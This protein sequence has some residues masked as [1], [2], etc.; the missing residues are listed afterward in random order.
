M[1]EPSGDKDA[2]MRNFDRGKYERLYTWLYYNQ[3]EEGYKCKVCET[4]PVLGNHKHAEKW[5]IE[6]QR[7]LSDHPIRTLNIHETSAK[8]KDAVQFLNNFKN[9]HTLESLQEKQVQKRIT[10]AEITHDG[11]LKLLKVTVFIVKKNWAHTQNFESFVRFVGEELEEAVLKEYLKVCEDRKN[12]TYLSSSAVTDFIHVI[13]N[14]IKEKTL[15][16]LR[17]ATDFTLLLDESTDEA[18]R[19]ELALLARLVDGIEVKN[20]FLDLIRLKRRDAKTVFGAVQ[21]FLTRENVDISK[22]RFAG[23]DG[24]STM[25]GSDGGVK[26]FFE[27]ASGHCVYVHCR[28]HRLALCFAH[29]IP[30]Y[31]ILQEFDSLL[32]NLFLMMKH[33]AVKS[34]IFE[35]VQTAYGVL[36]LKLIKGTVTRWLSHG[37]ACERVLDR[38]EPLISALD[39]IYER[40]KEPA[41]RG[42]RDQLIE[43]K[44]V[45][46]FCLMADI[47]ASTNAVQCILQASALNFLEIPS[48][49]EKLVSNLER[50]ANDPKFPPKCYFSRL[51]ELLEVTHLSAGCRF[52]LRNQTQFSEERFV[53]EIAK[54]LITELIAEVKVAFQIPVSLQGVS[55]FD[56]QSLP[57]EAEELEYFGIKEVEDLVHYYG[58]PK[59]KTNFSLLSSIKMG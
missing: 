23:M 38:F 26:V 45:A 18:N 21:E 42:V 10:E 31:D 1:L 57:Q 28:N 5:G 34:S 53:E 59:G 15:S 29:L 44:T 11:L 54:P 12:A 27:E 48:T 55:V 43:P 7:S 16:E 33:S 4:L 32:L 30:R 17:D 36:P 3:A 9:Q 35:E 13:S 50:K 8:H 56:P 22:T 58:S 52:Q 20:V 51:N 6:A 41:V 25:S 47:I 46:I 39:A 24:C 2:D 19:S 37:K 14:W 40:K 49:I